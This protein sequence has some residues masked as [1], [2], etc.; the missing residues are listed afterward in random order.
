MYS[1]MIY[2]NKKYNIDIFIEKSKEIHGDKYDYSL[3]EYISYRKKIKIICPLHGIFEQ[4]FEKHVSRRNGCPGCSNKKRHTNES[5]IKKSKEEHGDKYDYSLVKYVNAKTK[6]IIIC[7]IHGE[8]EQSPSCHMSGNGCYKCK[9]KKIS[10]SLSLNTQEFIIKS[11]KKHNNFYDY[12]LV[13][14]ETSHKKIKIICKKHGIFEQTPNSHLNG[15]GCPFCSNLKSSLSRISNK[16]DFI[17]K[18]IK[19]HGEKYNYNQI[20]YIRSN[21][22]VKIICSKHGLFLQ[23]PNNHLNGMGCKECANEQ[24]SQDRRSSLDDFKKKCVYLFGDKF[25]YTESIYINNHTP[26]NIKCNKHNFVFKQTPIS[27]LS[28]NNGC[29]FCNNRSIGEQIIIKFL[30]EHNIKYIQQKTFKDCKYKILLPF[31]FYIKSHNLLI[32]YNGKQHYEYIHYFH[33]NEKGF[34]EQKKR[35]KI[36]RDFSKTKNIK[37][38]DISYKDKKN[39]EKILLKELL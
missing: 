4:S 5:F 22:K 29:I 17:N 34:L 1:I 28:G 30:E 14:Y 3:S 37:L 21:E 26:I 36:K 19:I 25:D 20:D 2:M 39:I 11:N 12:S 32:E 24:L 10:K 31:D 27:H 23:T 6:V 38:L 9:G 16:K 7:P 18:S 35:D 33:K 15:R 13:E 8:F